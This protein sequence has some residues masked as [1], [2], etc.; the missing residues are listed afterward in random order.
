MKKLYTLIIFIVISCLLVS[1]SADYDGI[2]EPTMSSSL[3]FDWDT[4]TFT[5]INYD[6]IFSQSS[7][8]IEDIVILH[9]EIYDESL[10]SESIQSYEDLFA[11]MEPLYDKDDQTYQDI[12][13]LDSSEFQALL[14]DKNLSPTITDIIL[15]N[16]LKSLLSSNPYISISKQSYYEIRTSKTL[17]YEEITQLDLLQY[18]VYQLYPSYPIVSIDFQTLKNDLDIAF[19][20]TEDEYISLQLAFDLIQELK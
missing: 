20:I 8:P 12:L 14:A 19:S 5:N 1:C 4:L 7:T 6:D 10:S 15:F 11:L 9:Q 16:S 17:S 13:L 3:T 2:G 18:Y